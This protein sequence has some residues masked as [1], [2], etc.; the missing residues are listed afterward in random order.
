MER[1]KRYVFENTFHPVG[2][3]RPDWN[4]WPVS[5]CISATVDTVE[6]AFE[7]DL[8]LHIVKNK[9]IIKGRGVQ[10]Q[11]K[12][13][14]SRYYCKNTAQFIY[15]CFASIAAWQLVRERNQAFTKIV[16]QVRATQFCGHGWFLMLLVISTSCLFSLYSDHLWNSP[17][18]PYL[19][20]KLECFLPQIC[21]DFAVIFLTLLYT[22]WWCCNRAYI[23]FLSNS[24]SVLLHPAAE[25]VSWVRN[26]ISSHLFSQFCKHF[27]AVLYERGN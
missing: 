14:Q 16:T 26:N 13:Q 23:F 1:G 12:K 3:T 8:K 15:R 21:I 11:V 20:Y 4:G 18:M 7:F 2:S 22:W 27:L 9:G 24:V 25:C 19:S 5:V 6:R 17:D 10:M